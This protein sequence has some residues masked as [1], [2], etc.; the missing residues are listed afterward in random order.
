MVFEEMMIQENLSYSVNGLL[1]QSTG[2]QPVVRPEKVRQ[3]GNLSMGSAFALPISCHTFF[4]RQTK[5]DL[6]YD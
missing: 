6:L 1:S 3:V 5:F 4:L 2:Y